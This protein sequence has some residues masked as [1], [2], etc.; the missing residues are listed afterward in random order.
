MYRKYLLAGVF[1]LFLSPIALSAST[2]LGVGQSS[3]KVW[4]QPLALPTYRLKPPEL[5]PMFYEHESYQGAKKMI[6]PYPFQDGVTD[7]R[8]EKTYKAL[9]L[10]NKY[11]R[12]SILPELGGRLFSAIDKTNDYEIFY[13]QHVI[14]PALIGMLGA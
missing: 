1:V 9:Y 10:E 2:P 13:H 5:N 14:K 8:E 12:L 4:E 11:I 7:I 3:V 6:Y